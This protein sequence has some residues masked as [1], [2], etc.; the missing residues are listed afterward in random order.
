MG[1][2]VVGTV[3]ERSNLSE[4]E[5]RLAWYPSRELEGFKVEVRA[6]CR[7]I[8]CCRKDRR[9]LSPAFWSPQ[10]LTRGLELRLCGNRQKNKELAIW[11][12]LKAQQRSGGDPEFVAAVSRACTSAAREQAAVEGKRDY[13]EAQHDDLTNIIVSQQ[14]NS[15]KHNIVVSPQNNTYQH[16]ARFRAITECV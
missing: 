8:R 16:D 5:H 1:A 4:E 15:R 13:L 9:L 2:R 6:L 10:P 3:T 11:G 7:A 12:T 14:Q